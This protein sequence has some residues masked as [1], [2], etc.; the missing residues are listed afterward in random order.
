MEKRICTTTK[1][2]EFLNIGHSY[3]NF[4]LLRVFRTFIFSLMLFAAAITVKFVF[5]ERFELMTF[6]LDTFIQLFY[7]IFLSE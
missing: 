3:E 5:L 4:T 7:I 1:M 2:F 6:L